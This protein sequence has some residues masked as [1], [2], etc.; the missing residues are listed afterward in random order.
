MQMQ[1]LCVMF[2]Y[3]LYKRIYKDFHYFIYSFA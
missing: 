1:V 2:I 3:N